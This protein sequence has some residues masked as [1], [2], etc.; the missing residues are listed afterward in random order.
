MAWFVLI[1][2]GLFE[3]LAVTMMNRY[4][5][6]SSWQNLLGIV[7]SFLGGLGLLGYALRTI[8]MG[9][10]YAV[11]TGI[12]VVASSIIGIIYFGD[13]KSLGR[14]FFIGLILLS[15]V[16]LKLIV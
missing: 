5:R 16:G 13:S 2:A 8:P 3:T 10:G 12:S 7:L 1:V 11:W 15:V 14:I 4:A 6:D 9:T